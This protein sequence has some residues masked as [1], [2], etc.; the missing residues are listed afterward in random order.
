MSKS[1]I[2]SNK[3]KYNFNVAW[4][5]FQQNMVPTF[6]CQCLLYSKSYKAAVKKSVFYVGPQFVQEEFME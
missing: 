2:F 3:Y 6:T 4:N 1:C 5:G